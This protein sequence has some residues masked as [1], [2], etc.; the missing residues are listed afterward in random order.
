M[1]T[2]DWLVLFATTAFIVGWGIVRYRGAQTM[3]GYLRGGSTLRWPTIG[4]S[5]M[6]TQASAITFLSVPGQGYEDGMRFV[7]FYFGLPIAM[8]VV[9]A[10]FV[11]IYYR[12]KVYT[13]YEYLESR[14]DLKTR[15][16]GASLFLVSRGLAAGITIYA[17]AILLSSILGWPLYWTN[18]GIG[19]AVVLYTVA[20]GSKAVSQ[21]QKQQMVVVLLGLVATGFVACSK[22]PSGVG[23]DDAFSLAGALGR[24]NAVDASFALTDRYNL[25]SGLTG[26]FFLAL[27]YFGTD[28]S[29]VGRYLGGRSVAESRLGLLFNGMLKIP[30]Q[31]GIL[32]LGVMV[33]VF[34]MFASPP[35]FW[36]QPTLEAAR[37]SAA[38]PQ[39]AE[40]E[41]RWTDAVAARAEAANAFLAARDA[42]DEG[43]LDAATT[44][45]QAAQAQMD[46]TRETM[47]D[48][49]VAAVPNAER[50][51]RDYIF[52]GFALANLPAG[53]LG[54]LVAVIL[55]AAMSSIAGELSALGST[56]TVD[57]Y[58]RVLRPDAPE[59]RTLTMS[60]LFTVGWGLVAVAFATFATLV[61]NLIQA[62][63]ILGSLFYGTVLGMFLV[64]FF[65]K[66]VGG[67]AVF[68]AAIAAET[69]VVL[70]FAL[71]D[72]G[73]LWFNV[74]GCVGVIVLATL[75]QAVGLGRRPAPAG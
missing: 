10:V 61:D 55:A 4:L 62:V 70:V 47:K 31:A 56:T 18:I 25:W 50:E 13:A 26:G 73:Y 7:Q 32:F 17:P 64:A 22:M 43:A 11:P 48:A 33:F 74:I 3:D 60:K 29:Q 57:Y 27:A 52:L 20:G 63:N 8:V 5:V 16:L 41:G 35:V 53:L 24:V 72:V 14:F 1:A 67:T 59:Q 40:I 30:M 37:A 9:S 58:R 65:L 12:L 68:W 36:N 34:Y 39:I 69:G 46:A 15:L 49:I 75:L 19:V 2:L 51:D 42:G 44:R 6:A 38:G 54:L 21:T 66:R 71:T 28:Q 45:L 23:V